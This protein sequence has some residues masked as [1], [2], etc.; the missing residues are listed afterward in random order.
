MINGNMEGKLKTYQCKQKTKCKQNAANRH[1]GH[2]STPANMLLLT[3]AL[4]KGKCMRG[5][6]TGSVG[7]CKQMKQFLG[8][9]SS[10]IERSTICHPSA[11]CADGEMLAAFGAASFGAVALGSGQ[12]AFGS[13]ALAFGSLAG[14][15]GSAAGAFGSGAAAFGSVAAAFGSFCI[16]PAF[17]GGGGGSNGGGTGGTA[18]GDFPLPITPAMDPL[19]APLGIGFATG[20]GKASAFAGGGPAGGFG[21]PVFFQEACC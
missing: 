18:S 20:P 21:V 9:P 7:S 13:G 11:S 3:Q 15:I 6:A 17:A 14:A 16:G 8:N 2:L 12:A 10:I 4:Q 1:I 19:P 5:N